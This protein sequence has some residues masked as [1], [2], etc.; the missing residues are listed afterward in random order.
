MA[1]AT[2]R[3]M[4]T[5]AEIDLALE[6]FSQGLN[7]C[8]ISRRTSIPRTTLRDWRRG[9]V[10]GNRQSGQDSAL[11]PS[12]GQRRHRFGELPK[13]KHAYLL[14]LY[15]G[16]GCI[17]TQRRR[18]FR[19][20]ITLDSKYPGIVRECVLAIEAVMPLNRVGRLERPD[21]AVEVGCSSR[22][23]PCLIPQ[24]G[25]GKKHSR[26]I[27]LTG[28]QRSLIRGHEQAL[29]KGLIH[30]DGSRFTNTIRHP[31]ATYYYPRY[32]FSNKSG[33]IRA[34]FGETCDELGIAWRAMGPE[35]I[36][37]A[38]A[39]SVALMDQFVGPKR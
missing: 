38:Q 6:L 36:S 4:R 23:W 1:V 28:W 20:R 29:L 26:R 34:I 33:D 3:E 15:L 11:C 16:D 39:E 24:S 10:P 25:P 18:V 14:G 32:C 5:R 30:S 17:S 19:L 31:G 8:E 9:G 27:K 13:E 7:D 21:N 35:Q 37:I 2:L 12:C 22:A